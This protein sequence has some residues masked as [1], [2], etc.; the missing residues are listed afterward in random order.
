MSSVEGPCTIINSGDI[1][2]YNGM[3]LK[4]DLEKGKLFGF[5]VDNKK[6]KR[7]PLRQYFMDGDF[8]IGASLC[9]TLTKLALRYI[10][11]EKNEV[12]QNRF[13][14]RM[15]LVMSSILHLG[16][17]GFPTKPI[18]NDDTD[19]IFLCLKT[20]SERTPETVEVFQHFCRDALG[21]MLEAQHDEEAQAL[22]EKQKSA[23][24]VQAD[25]PVQFAQLSSGKE[26][27]LG[28]NV[29]ESSLMKEEKEI[30]LNRRIFVKTRDSQV[31]FFYL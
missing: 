12:E 9:V 5:L 23:S 10:E 6:D 24:K 18:T 8:F 20:L 21:K 27:Q 19:R 29:F 15:M 28:E 11:L 1:D 17:S 7:P 22:K 25:D 30:F 2:P 4:Q 3:Q 14:A 31:D 16:K 26:S 13:C